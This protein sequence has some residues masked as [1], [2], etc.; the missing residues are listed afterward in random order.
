MKLFQKKYF[1]MVLVKEPHG[2]LENQL[3]IMK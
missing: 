1:Q 2:L 3:D